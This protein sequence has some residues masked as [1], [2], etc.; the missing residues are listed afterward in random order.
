MVVAQIVRVRNS[1]LR[2]FRIHVDDWFAST[3]VVDFQPCHGSVIEVP[4]GF[5]QVTS[6]LALP[7]LTTTSG[8]F[9]VS[10]VHE[11]DGKERQEAVRCTVGPLE[12]DP[13][14][15]DLDWLQFHDANWE[16]LMKEKWM[17][18]GPRHTFG[19]I[20]TA[21]NM[22]LTFRDSPDTDLVDLLRFE[23]E[24]VCAAPC[25]VFLNI[26]DL[27]AGLT[28]AND[29]LCNSSFNLMG[30]FHAAVEVYGE[31][32]SFY[33]TPR[34]DACGVC[35]SVRP[36]QHPVHVYRQSL[37]LGVTTLEEWEVR[38]LIR[39]TLAPEWTGG[40]YD[41]LRRNCIHFCDELAIQLGVQSVPDWVK[42]LHETGAGLSS[43]VSPLSALVPAAPEDA[44]DSEDEYDEANIVGTDTEEEDP[45]RKKTESNSDGHTRRFV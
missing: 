14:G 2:T 38:Y 34:A 31:E 19:V 21:E 22:E 4:P 6:N 1:T 17:P 12:S 35:R 26:F 44:T 8:G 33:R 41:L 20:G 25:T 28:M 42:A 7:W 10:E 40:K 45:K 29:V 5:D 32:W 11:E 9:K 15:R 23:R 3:P 43:A 27:M 13:Y 39:K 24:V 30:A 36:R 16:P 37:N 18:I